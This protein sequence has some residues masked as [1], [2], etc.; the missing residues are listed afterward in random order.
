[1]ILRLTLKKQWFDLILSGKKVFEYREYKKHWTSR[2]LG[3]NGIKNF[4]EIHFTNGYG[5]NMP[6]M[7]VSCIGISIIKGGHCCPES[8]EQLD[9]DKKYFVIGLGSVV[10]S[11]NH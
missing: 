9:K 1:M 5:K 4:K 6:S 11:G 2:L 8:G 10:Y 3:K 7:R